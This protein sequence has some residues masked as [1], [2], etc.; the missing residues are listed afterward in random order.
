MNRLL[1]IFSVLLFAS[2]GVKVAYTDKLKEEYNLNEDN[3]KKIQFYSSSTIILERKNSMSDQETTDNG[4]IVSSENRVE[5]RIIIPPSTKCVFEKFEANGDIH[6]R[7]EV[8]QNKTLRFA[9]RKGQTNGRF[10]LL[11]NSWDAQKGGELNYGNLTYYA[12]TDSGS[13][14]LMVAVKKLRKVKRKDRIVKGMKV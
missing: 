14:Y 1:L 6:V 12:T 9:I 8:G 10:Y 11:A 2:C 5:N 4:V 3:L 13:A 7:F